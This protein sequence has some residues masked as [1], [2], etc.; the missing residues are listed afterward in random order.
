MAMFDFL[1]GG[2]SPEM[3]PTSATAIPD[4]LQA[5]GANLVGAAQDVAQEQ[6]IPYTDPQLAAMTPEQLAAQPTSL[7]HG[8]RKHW[9]NGTCNGSNASSYGWTDSGTNYRVYE[10]LHDRRSGHRGAKN[11][12]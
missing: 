3:Q 7:R 12:G 4:Y 1:F 6:Y 11:E 5:A 9:S 2:S 8:G 10:S